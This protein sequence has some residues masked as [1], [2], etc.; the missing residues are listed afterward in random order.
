MTRL[1]CGVIV[2]NY[3]GFLENSVGIVNIIFLSFCACFIIDLII[4]LKPLIILGLILVF[5]ILIL[6]IFRV[7]I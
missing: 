1:K 4:I 6:I 7:F 3:L 2:S 5:S